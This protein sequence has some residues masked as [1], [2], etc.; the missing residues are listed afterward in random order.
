M[1]LSN[2]FAILSAASLTTAVSVSYDR[3]YDDGSRSLTSVSCSD[4]E[5]GLITTHGWKTQGQVAGFPY[6]GGADVIAGWNSP[7]CGT[8]WRLTYNGRSIHVLAIDVA[9]NGFNIAFAAM[10]D[11]T[12]GNAERLGRVEAEIT[13]VR[14]RECGIEEVKQPGR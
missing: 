11:L 13:P 7:S 1:K 2:L 8:C 6:I 5:N 10:N 4:G 12:N 9:A 3:A 14:D